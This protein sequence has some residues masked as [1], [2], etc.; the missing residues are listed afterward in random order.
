[1][2]SR[3]DILG[4]VRANLE[5]GGSNAA[6]ARARAEDWL[7]RRERG[8]IP[9]L[10]A[11]LPLLKGAALVGVDVRQ[12]FLYETELAAAHLSELLGWVGDGVLT[13]P[14]GREFA[15]DEF[16]PALEYALSGKGQGKT[17]LRVCADL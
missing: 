12:F 11:N 16:V 3:E 10:P 6:A 17:I 9:A 4:R 15:F 1:M 14:V 5:R 7:A 13:P 2:S 8:P